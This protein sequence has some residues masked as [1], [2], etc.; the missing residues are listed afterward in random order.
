MSSLNN[1]NVVS[2]TNIRAIIR[3]SAFLGNPVTPA[4]NAILISGPST[5][6][7]LTL[8]S[9]TFRGFSQAVTLNGGCT[10][11]ISAC[12]FELCASGVSIINGT[13]TVDGCSF[14]NL[15]TSGAGTSVSVDGAASTINMV[16]CLFNHRDTNGVAQGIGVTSTS[17]AKVAMSG[18][19]INWAALALQIGLSNN[20][21]TIST[22]MTS[23][24]VCIRNCTADIAQYG[25]TQFSLVG[26]VYDAT[27]TTIFS[28]TNV[29]IAAFDVSTANAFS[30]G[31]GS[32]SRS[33]IYQLLLGEGSMNPKLIYEP[34]YYGGKGSIYENLN[35]ETT[36]SG[37]QSAG[38]TIK[39]AVT[40]DSSKAASMR[41]L[42]DV[43]AV[44]VNDNIR[45][46]TLSKEGTT[47][48]LISVY[49]NSDSVGQALRSPNTLSSFDGFNNV[50]NYPFATG[51]VNLPSNATTVLT[52][53]GDTNLYRSDTGMLK[54]DTQM[55]I[56]SFLTLSTLTAN[57][58]VVSDNTLKLA[59]SVVTTT[60]L[61]Y[62][63]GVTSSI[64]A[65]LNSKF[66]STGGAFTNPLLGP[67]GSPS[68]PTYAFSSDPTSGVYYSLTQGLLLSTSSTA[69]VR[70]ALTGELYFLGFT[71][72]VVH[73]NA[74][75]QL[76]SSLITNADVD[77]N[78][79]IVDTKLGVIQTAGKVSN[80]ATT[81]TSANTP[82]AIVSRDSSGNITIG[83]LVTNSIQALNLQSVGVV[84]TDATGNFSTSLIT[85][86]DI[87]ASAGIVDTKLATIS[88]A[89]KVANSATTAVTGASPNTIVLR[90][91]SG[92][93]FF[94]VLTANAFANPS[95]T[96]A[97]VVHNN[98]SGVLSSSLIVNADVDPAAA[99]VDTKLAT[100]QTSGKVANSATSATGT[101]APNTIALRDGGGALTATSETLT[102]TSNQLVLGSGTTTTIS[103]TAPSVSRVLTIPDPG[104]AANFLMSA[105]NQ[106]ASGVQSF[107][108]GVASSSTTTGSVV[109]TGGLG[110]S[111]NVTAGGS[112]TAT[113]EVLTNTSNQLV[114]GS[115]TTTTITVPTPAASRVLTIPD[116][117]G[118]ATF[119]MSVGNQSASGVQSFTAGVASS[120]T[121]TGSVVITGGLGVSGNVTSASHSV[122]ATSNQ[123]VLGTGNTTT[124][125]ATGPAASRVVSI[126]D[127]GVAN[128]NFLL[129]AGNQSASGIQSFT[130][131]LASTGPT[132]GSVVITGGLGISGSVNLSGRWLTQ[133][134]PN[135]YSTAVT[136]LAATQTITTTQL[137]G[138]II[139]NTAGNITLTLPTATLIAAALVA[140]GVTMFIG[141]TI[142][143]IFMPT[144]GGNI[145][146][147]A[148]TNITMARA[149]TTIANNASG[150]LSIRF[151]G[152]VLNS[153]TAVAYVG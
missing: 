111:G 71:G 42:S 7:L 68:A 110:L 1:T 143:C 138:G 90:D 77:A 140:A 120:S 80:S 52:W 151:T 18:C 97:G 124:I 142:D 76:S 6:T 58:A 131:G 94:N 5:S 119:L 92:N 144:G 48:N 54:T 86:A 78:A 50:L 31:S 137:L 36:V 2:I 57:R 103:A 51:G 106:S 89:G 16:G 21:D 85:N 147:A 126:P 13:C 132:N 73:S 152:V 121:T 145:T 59:S 115:G 9:T 146:I 35:A 10:A 70:V 43:G 141:L 150:T 123:I 81:A 49:E 93:G 95:F 63:S 40:T 79:G 101:A 148:G 117:G 27:K 113:N 24:S 107:T 139:I 102:S 67:N 32:D 28:S 100:I 15:P 105:G 26:G 116:P 87:S 38:D 17:Q 84:H 114:F 65:Q 8:M 83:G 11:R 134:G 20:S 108:A 99:I 75:G 74:S 98:A 64:Q 56:G 22:Q 46:W 39:Y 104:G 69:R 60:E 62:V 96:T 29:N 4:G 61:G 53:G 33:T 133:T 66:G 34:S 122:T 41:I 136:S 112:V 19:G 3:N 135:V 129:S 14:V 88:T 47:G 118:A 37:V 25:T 125:N 44:G 128:A 23:S 82:L 55:T 12:P 153:E 91:N 130:N 127:P 30:L 149:T 72:G 45:G 109:I